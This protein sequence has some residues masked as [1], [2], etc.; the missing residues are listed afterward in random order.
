MDIVKM[1]KEAYISV[2]GLEK[3]D[4]LTDR[5]KHDAIMIILKDLD[6]SLSRMEV[7]YEQV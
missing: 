4:K 2:M 7:K 3:W 6:R 1:A 5:Q